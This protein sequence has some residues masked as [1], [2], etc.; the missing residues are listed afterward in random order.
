MGCIATRHDRRAKL[1]DITRDNKSFIALAQ[2]PPRLPFATP[3]SPPSSSPPA[4]TISTIF[5]PV[6]LGALQKESSGIAAVGCLCVIVLTSVAPVRT[7]CY[8]LPAHCALRSGRA[9]PRA[10]VMAPV[11]GRNR[12]LSLIHVPEAARGWRAGQH[13]QVR[14]AGRVRVEGASAQRVLCGAGGVMFAGC[15]WVLV[16]RHFFYPYV[17]SFPARSSFFIPVLY[18]SFLPRHS[19][20][21]HAPLL[22]P[23]P[24]SFCITRRLPSLTVYLRVSPLFLYSFIRSSSSASC[25]SFPAHSFLSFT[26]L[27]PRLTFPPH[28]SPSAPPSSAPSLLSSFCST[29][30]L[31]P[32]ADL[33]AHTHLFPLLLSRP[34][35][36]PHVRLRR[37]PRPLLPP[38]LL[39]RVWM[40]VYA[41]VL[42]LLSPLRS[43]LHLF[44]VC[45]SALPSLISAPP[46]VL[47]LLPFPLPHVL[48]PHPTSFLPSC[49]SFFRAPVIL[50]LLALHSAASRPSFPC[51]P[52]SSC[53][54]RTS[55]DADAECSVVRSLPFLPLPRA[56]FLRISSPGIPYFPLLPPSCF[57]PFLPPLLTPPLRIALALAPVFSFPRVSFSR[58]S[59]SAPP[60]HPSLPSTPSLPLPLKGE[61]AFKPVTKAW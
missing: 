28:P 27:L 25:A 54:A 9:P 3:H 22:P 57:R 8:N 41:P 18:P 23:S 44:V 56:C 19:P 36:L 61:P 38:L 51:P 39:P 53:L 42:P 31:P 35:T 30:L 59:P 55:P 7:W 32:G 52:S 58:F 47:H 10:A 21:L 4:S 40:S 29:P 12:G 11:E 20:C 46:H 50:P 33:G 13:V 48:P 5:I 14:A 26:P 45:L 43:V 2:L 24:A 37:R 6:T 49:C 34:R 15:V 60:S 17:Y 16:L 1:I